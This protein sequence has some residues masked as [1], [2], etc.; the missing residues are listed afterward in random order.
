MNFAAVFGASLCSG[1]ALPACHPENGNPQRQPAELPPIKSG[2]LSRQSRP[3]LMYTLIGTA[4]LNDVDP[5]AWLGDV[6]RRIA[7]HPASR[8]YELL[9]WHWKSPKPWPLPPEYPS[10]RPSPDAYAC[11]GAFG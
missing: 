6:L 3:P 10:S 5:Q 4:K 2:K 11:A 8:L 9:P 1:Y 7:D